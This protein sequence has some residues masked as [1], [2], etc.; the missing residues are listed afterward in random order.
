M[1]GWNE[2]PV[3]IT[4]IQ[5][6]S[7]R[8]TVM[9]KLP[10]ALCPGAQRVPGRSDTISCLSYGAQENLEK[11]FD[12]WVSA[13]LMRPGAKYEGAQP[14]SSIVIVREFGTSFTKQGM[15]GNIDYNWQ[16]FFYCEN[17]RSPSG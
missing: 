6:I 5:D 11:D 1:G 13:G 17:W 2:V 12:K 14:G 3:D 4:K 15:P 8:T 7:L 9:V 10:A 16:R